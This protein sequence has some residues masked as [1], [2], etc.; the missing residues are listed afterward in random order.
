MK[1]IIYLLVV[2]T[3]ISLLMV[4]C[5]SAVNSH[6]LFQKVQED[7]SSDMIDHIVTIK[8]EK[9]VW[10]L[11]SLIKMMLRI[12]FTGFLLTFF[13][14]LF[15]TI[16][17]AIWITYFGGILEILLTAFGL[18]FIT[19]FKW[20]VLLWDIILRIFQNKTKIRSVDVFQT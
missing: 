4:P 20:P 6:L 11:S 10:S 15:V 1:P 9:N 12:Y 19:A 14:S 17:V 16:P 8:E 2:F 5:I 13:L 18:S 3:S 7:L